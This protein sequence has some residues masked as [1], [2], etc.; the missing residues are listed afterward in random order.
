MIHLGSF[1]ALNLI[2]LTLA[3]LCVNT[4][5]LTTLIVVT[6]FYACCPASEPWTVLVKLSL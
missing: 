1:R 5:L 3:A 6:K 4:L 2:A